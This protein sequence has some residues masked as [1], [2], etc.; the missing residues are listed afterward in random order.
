MQDC[1]SAEGLL[2]LDVKDVFSMTHCASQNHELYLS[3]EGSLLQAMLQWL[4][5]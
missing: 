5:W 1:K 3:F 4:P 2:G